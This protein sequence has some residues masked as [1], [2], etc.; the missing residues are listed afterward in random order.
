MGNYVDV[1][2]QVNGVSRV[3]LHKWL[4]K[5]NKCRRGIHREFVNAVQ[6]A[7]AESEF[8]DVAVLLK[9][10]Q[11]YDVVKTKTVVGPNGENTTTTE[12]S[13]E[14]NPHV[15]EWRLERKFPHRWGRKDRLE[16]DNDVTVT[17]EVNVRAVLSVVENL[18][19]DRDYLTWLRERA[20]A[21]PVGTDASSVG[22]NGERRPV[23]DG[24]PPG[25]HRPGDNGHDQE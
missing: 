10:I 2:A 18:R 22:G 17:G 25:S 14:F 9:A 20:I 19:G 12:R 7:I 3:A 6:Q 24:S 5:G 15:A 23:E 13:H 16:V 21:G 8:R 1:A 11:G 4:K